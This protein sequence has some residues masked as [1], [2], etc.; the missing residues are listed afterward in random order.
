MIWRC[1]VWFSAPFTALGLVAWG[2]LL[3]SRKT[4]V[5]GVVMLVAGLVLGLWAASG[6]E[7]G[8]R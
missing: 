8:W 7:M 3:T 5:M 1:V 4:R 6:L 2:H